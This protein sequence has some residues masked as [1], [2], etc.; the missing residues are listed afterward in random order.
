MSD[1]QGT[2]IGSGGIDCPVEEVWPHK[3]YNLPLFESQ[4][5]IDVRPKAAYDAEHISTALHFECSTPMNEYA[6]TSFFIRVVELGLQPEHVSPVVLYGAETLESISALQWL[7]HRLARIKSQPILAPELDSDFLQDS[8]ESFTKRVKKSLRKVWIIK[9]G[10]RAFKESFPIL[11][12]DVG[13]EEQSLPCWMADGLFLG[14]RSVQSLD[15]RYNGQ[16]A[17]ERKVL[18]LLGITHVVV[19]AR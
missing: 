14:S 5:V 6:V 12:G 3:V 13:I 18:A 17:Y 11:C 2:L 4:F 8:F 15:R 19:N 9:G 10:Y 1:D 7:A 16:L